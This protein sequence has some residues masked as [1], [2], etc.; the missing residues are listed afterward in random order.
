[1]AIK[2]QNTETGVV[3]A[4]APVVSKAAAKAAKAVAGK[5]EKAAK[6]NG[7][8]AKVEK[9]AEQ[10]AAEAKAKEEAKA[11]KAAEREKEKAA[12]I[13]EA[14]N[15]ELA[16]VAKCET[17]IAPI[18]GQSL[19]DELAQIPLDSYENCV[20]GYVVGEKIGFAYTFHAMLEAFKFWMQDKGT[21]NGFAEDFSDKTGKGR[22]IINKMLVIKGQPESL[23]VPDGNKILFDDTLARAVALASQDRAAS[24]QAQRGRKAGNQAPDNSSRGKEALSTRDKVYR[25]FEAISDEFTYL[26]N[27]EE[28]KDNPAWSAITESLK[29]VYDTVDSIRERAF[30]V[31]ADKVGEDTADAAE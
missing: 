17:Y 9:T 20:K 2:T 27:L 4:P 22:S 18:T 16:L 26:V 1:M 3:T 8:T 19:L 11:A 12:K 29:E 28:L 24:G 14:K 6:K 31:V 23:N 30:D 13:A 10:I 25:A 7:K 5:P 15:K 21:K